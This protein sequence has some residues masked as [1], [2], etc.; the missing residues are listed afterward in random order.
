M[1][2]LPSR[3]RQAAPRRPRHAR[4]QASHRPALE[5]LEDRTVP[6]AVAPP[7]GLVSWWSA[8]GHAVDLAG[9]NDGILQGGTTYAAGK[10]GQAFSLDGSDDFVRVAHDPSLNPSA[11]LTIEA[12]INSASTAGA[13][14]IVSKW[15]DNTRDWSYIFKDHNNSD[16]LRFE[17]S[18]SVHN[19][20]ADLA[21]STSIRTGTWTHVAATYDTN[22][23]RLYF[24]GALDASQTVGP[25]R[26]IDSS[27]TDLLIGAVF[28]GGR[29][30]ENFAGL[31]DE[32]SIYNRALT[33]AEIQSIY[34]AGADGKLKPMMV[35]GSN[36]ARGDILAV[37]PTDFVIDF[38]FAYD[39]ATV[40][41][42]DLTVNGIAADAVT[43][44]DADTVTFHYATSPVTAQ[45][46]QTMHLGVGAV[47][48]PS[49]A[50]SPQA[51]REW[52]R[53]FRYDAVAMQVAATSPAAGGLLP[54]SPPAPVKLLLDFNE[55]FAAA[56]VG[57][58]DLGVSQGTV[59]AAQVVDTDTVEYTLSG[60]REGPLAVTVAAGA[61]TD[62]YGNP[63]LPFSAAYEIDIGTA[64]FPSPLTPQNP[65]GSLVYQGSVSGQFNTRALTIVSPGSGGLQSSEKVLYRGGELYV[66]SRGNN[67][68]LRFDA[69]TGAPRPAAGNSGAVFASGNGLSDPVGLAFGPD[70]N[71]YVSSG[72]TDNI[73]RY[74]G[75]TGAFLSAFVASGSGGLDRPNGLV[76]HS[77]GKLYVAS[78]NT[79]AVLRYDG[80]T[81]AFLDTFIVSGSGGLSQPTD[82]LFGPDG[83]LYVSSWAN[84]RVL[85]YDGATGAFLDTVVAAGSGGLQAPNG[86][87]FGGDGSLYVVGFSSNNVLHYNGT[88]GALLDAPV[89]AG[90]GLTQL[91]GLLRTPDG[92]LFVSSLGTDSV[93]QVETKPDFYK[94]TLSA[95]QT[96]TFSTSTPADGPGEFVNN[97][98]AHLELYNG[99]QVLVVS[100][101]VLADGRNE[102][103]TY[104]VPATG[105]YYVK[106][107]RENDTAGEYVLDPVATGGAPSGSVKADAVAAWVAAGVEVGRLRAVPVPVSDLPGNKPGFVSSSAD[108]LADNIAGAGRV[109]EPRRWED[110]EFTT[111]GDQGEQG[112]MD[113]LTALMHEVG[114]L[115][116]LDHDATGVMQEALAPGTRRSPSPEALTASAGTAV[117]PGQSPAA[118]TPVWDA[119]G[120]SLSHPA[121]FGDP[122]ALGDSFA[123]LA[124]ADALAQAFALAVVQRQGPRA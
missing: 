5:A 108:W 104:L 79:H 44:T 86:L 73:L 101:V 106:V 77:D 80:T 18:E 96:V 122:L 22:T 45:G 109:V 7:S 32:V 30:S 121:A 51:L 43:L 37:P 1:F 41:A 94:V 115:L 23:V 47:Q 3:P 82:L 26:F 68:I 19:D 52:D 12:W 61:L 25:N 54:L 116:G 102:Q 13:R 55:A 38:S 71:L 10:V 88:T 123:A 35:L 40:Q 6:T 39:P 75:T 103:I 17:L 85:R 65:T 113:L 14:D 72:A 16:K 66:V 120:W 107:S 74:S 48:T 8:D 90:G 91:V 76:F 98:D 56:S 60:L 50:A 15:N 49:T 2:P 83:N 95:G 81:G 62:A 69:A 111:P 100:G 33:A 89:Q 27:V 119:E 57:V 87:A 4:R 46:V 36:P 78:A 63:M 24:N 64:P 97:L 118:L 59:T 70:G 28:A 11:G 42:G 67:H 21:G 99:S 53:A 92:R 9:R 114:H 34:N 117:V 29:I 20:L 84:D 110:S 58:D 31:I 112:R 93:L 124:N 105:T